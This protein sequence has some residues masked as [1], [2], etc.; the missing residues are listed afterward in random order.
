M[1]GHQCLSQNIDKSKLI[2]SKYFDNSAK[3]F[4]KCVDNRKE[5]M[6]Q[7]L[8]NRLTIQP[9]ILTTNCTLTHPHLCHLDNLGHRHKPRPE[10]SLLLI[11]NPNIKA[12][13]SNYQI[14][15]AHLM[16]AIVLVPAT[17]LIARANLHN[18][19]LL[20][21]VHHIGQLS[22]YSYELCI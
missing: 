21:K 8:P 20:H 2:F 16:N 15:S 18:R 22:K 17:E 14:F 19:W 13:Y 5:T 7:N 4:D 3:K 10:T 9:K 12:G 1:Q 6:Y 11:V